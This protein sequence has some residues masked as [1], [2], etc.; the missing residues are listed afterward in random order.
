MLAL[1]T[2]NLDHT[3]ENFCLNKTCDVLFFFSTVLCLFYLSPD[4]TFKSQ[5]LE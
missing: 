3:L 4:F 1:H 5:D 2:Y